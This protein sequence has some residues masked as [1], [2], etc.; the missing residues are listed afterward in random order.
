MATPSCPAYR[1]RRRL[2]D[3]FPHPLAELDQL[4]AADLARH[5]VSSPGFA[6]L[7]DQPSRGPAPDP[8]ELLRASQRLRNEQ[9]FADFDAA[10]T[11]LSERMDPTD[12]PDLHRAFDDETE[13]H[14]VYWGLVTLIENFD[15]AVGTRVFVDVLPETVPTARDWMKTLAI[16]KLNDENARIALIQA[17]R[18]APPPNRAALDALLLELSSETGDA[19]ATKAAGA[20]AL[21]R[22]DMT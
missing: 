11:Q 20:L 1:G 9:Q 21:L 16:A 2:D 8:I 15:G 6:Q 12:L 4:P 5:L 7:S 3:P 18:Q 22:K 13:D 19:L 10:L 17:G 14:E